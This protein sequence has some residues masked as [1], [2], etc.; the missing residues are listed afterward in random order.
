MCSFWV[1]FLSNCPD[2][3]PSYKSL[4]ANRACVWCTSQKRRCAIDADE[5]KKKKTVIDSPKRKTGKRKNRVDSDDI[6]EVEILE[7][8]SLWKKS[9]WEWEERIWRKQV[10]NELTDI[11]GMIK[12]IHETVIGLS[13]AM[14]MKMETS[15]QVRGMV[16]K[17]LEDDEDADDDDGSG[18]EDPVP[19]Q[20]TGDAEMEVVAGVEEKADSE[21]EVGGIVENEEDQDETMK[22]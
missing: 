13:R 18:V 21:K 20:G 15:R 11:K 6:D 8:K 22:Q 1:S 2:S 17:L 10:E 5:L 4:R 9:D 7:E 3:P 12:F 14:K 19:T 16:E